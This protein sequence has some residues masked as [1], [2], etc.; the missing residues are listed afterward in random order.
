MV[1]NLTPNEEQEELNAEPFSK[2]SKL[3]FLKICKLKLPCLSYLSNELRLL[4]W[5]EYPFK[6]FP[7]SFQPHK[8]VELIMQCSSIKQ[9]P[10]EFNV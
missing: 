4:E 7:K 6:S 1:L 5:H 3:R 8:L 10:R 2:M 9:F